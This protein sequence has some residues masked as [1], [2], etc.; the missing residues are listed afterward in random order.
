MLYNQILQVYQIL[1]ILIGI[2]LIYIESIYNKI[3]QILYTLY[4]RLQNIRLQN[5]RLC[6][7]STYYCIYKIR[8]YIFIYSL[9]GQIIL[10][11]YI[12]I[13]LYILYT[14]YIVLSILYIFYYILCIL[15]KVYSK[16]FINLYFLHDQQSVFQLKK[17]FANSI[18]GGHKQVN[19]TYFFCKR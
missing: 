3:Y 19:C 2:Y 8:L 13:R 4:I 1:D 5:I 6:Y 7:Q 9:L 17:L 11:I 15:N 12:N 10:I 16:S 18:V 14:I